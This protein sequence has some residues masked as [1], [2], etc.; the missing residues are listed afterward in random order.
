MDFWIDIAIA[1]L[2]RLLKDRRERPKWEAALKKVHDAIEAAFPHMAAEAS[3]VG[4]VEG[5]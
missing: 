3:T 5:D 4:P 1:V 2:L